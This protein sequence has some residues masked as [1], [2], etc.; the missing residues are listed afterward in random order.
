MLFSDE[1]TYDNLGFRHPPEEETAADKKAEELLKNSP[2]A[3]K[4]DSAGLFLRQ[5]S[6]RAPALN[7]L[8]TPHLGNGLAE[9]GAVNR[10]PELMNAAPKLDPNKL[11][12]IAALPLGG[13]V[14]MNAWDDHVELVK[15]Q[16]VAITS[17]REK[18]P[19][20]VTPF[21]PRLSRFASAQQAPTQQ[22][23]TQPDSPTTA[24]TVKPTN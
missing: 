2:Y 9:A 8:L 15:S 7:S 18:M 22:G 14:K 12:Q 11:D 3:Q 16:P 5:L 13:R 19:F 21:L 17:A 1:N 4:L 10:M 6:E 20:E 23:S 24:A